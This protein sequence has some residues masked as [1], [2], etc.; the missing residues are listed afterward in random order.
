MKLYKIFIPKKYNNGSLI[1][2]AKTTELLNEVEKRFGS[3]TLD[4]FGKLPLIGVWNDPKNKERYVDEVQIPEL[5]V[6]DTIDIK[7]WITASKELWRQKLEQAE[8][9]IMVQDAEIIF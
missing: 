9:F 3:Y 6:E 1:P 7:R 4:P 5:F 8:L 2:L